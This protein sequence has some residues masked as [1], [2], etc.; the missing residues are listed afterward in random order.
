MPE[1]FM[2]VKAAEET[3]MD[4]LSGVTQQKNKTKTKAAKTKVS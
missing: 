2:Q 1:K 3:Y 4:T